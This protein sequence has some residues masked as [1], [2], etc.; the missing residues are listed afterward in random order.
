MS[1]RSTV[2]AGPGAATGRPSGKGRHGP[3]APALTGRPAQRAMRQHGRRF[4]W[5]AAA[6]WARPCWPGCSRR[7]GP[8]PDELAVVEKLAD[9][10]DELERAVPRRDVVGRSRVAAEGVVIAVK[11][12]TSS[13]LCRGRR[14]PGASGCCRSRPASR[15]PRSRTRSA[16]ACRSCGRC[17]TRRP[18]SAPARRRSPAGT[19]ATDDDLA[20]A[21]AILGAVGTVVRVPERCSTPSPACRGRARRTC[22]SSPRRSIEPAC[23]SGLPRDVSAALATQTLLGAARLLPRPATRRRR[24]GHGDLARRHDGRGPASARAARRPGRVPRRRQRRHRASSDSA[25]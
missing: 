4:S 6:G 8:R 19:T 18:W 11:P 2:G 9:R 25:R 23:S 1:F 16:T 24:C 22:S 14:R 17:R 3:L 7:V 10:R 13:G 15:S 12:A 5:W 21:E 20:W